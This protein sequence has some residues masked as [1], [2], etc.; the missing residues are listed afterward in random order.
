MT[1][2]NDNTPLQASD[3]ID[4]AARRAWLAS[5]PATHAA[6]H[7]QS[8]C[9]IWAK[10]EADEITFFGLRLWRTL[11]EPPRL[12]ANDNEPEDEDAESGDQPASPNMD[13]ELVDVSAKQLAYAA[14][15]GMVRF[16]GNRLVKVWNGHKWT[17][18]D[19]EFGKVR[20]R[21]S[22]KADTEQFDAEMPDAQVELARALDL[23]RLR[24]MLGPKTCT[25]LD[26]AAGDSTLAEIGEDLGFAGQYATRMAGKQ[27]RAAAVALH[28]I[29]LKLN[30]D[31]A[32]NEKH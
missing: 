31:H 32:P 15:N 11:N 4:L 6:H 3:F 12:A 26:M 2:A 20:Q 24:K 29:Q 8:P 28:A 19:A 13:R 17:S 1:P 9:A 10:R 30:T 16:V 21:K 7:E 23:E 27:V 5:A 14:E 18:P 22:E 25:V